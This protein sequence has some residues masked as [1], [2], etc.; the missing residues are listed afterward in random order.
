MGGIALKSSF[1]TL[2]KVVIQPKPPALLTIKPLGKVNVPIASTFTAVAASV[3]TKFLFAKFD[4]RLIK[5]AIFT[6]TDNRYTDELPRSTSKFTAFE[7]ISGIS[8]TRPE[9]LSV[10][11]F[12]PI[13][14]NNGMG[15]TAA[16][17][18]LDAQVKLMN[19]R[20]EAMA[21]LIKDLKTDPILAEQLDQI[22][23]DFLVHVK[24]LKDRVEFLATLQKYTENISKM[25]DLRDAQSTV[26]AASVLAY[27]YNALFTNITS[28]QSTL[29]AYTYA[30][31]LS[32]HGFNKQSVSEFSSTK[33]F[34]QTLYEA[35]KILR[36]GSDELVG[37]DASL[38]S[39]DTDPVTINRRVYRDPH[40]ALERVRM[41][42]LEDLRTRR[43]HESDTRLNST[44][45]ELETDFRNLDNV[46]TGATSEEVSY[47]LKI[48]TL[49]REAAYSHALS[50]TVTAGLL[51]DYGYPLR[52][53]IGNQ[54]LFDAVFGQLGSRITDNRTGTNSN[55][56]SSIVSKVDGDKAVL[57]YEVD[58]LEDEQ[59]SVFTPGASYY[60]T[61]AVRPGIS[62]AFSHEHAAELVTRMKSVVDHYANFINCFNLLPRVGNVKL[63]QLAN[64]VFVLE[65]TAMTNAL[66]G[67]L[68]ENSNGQLKS[69]VIG[70]PIID[71]LGE[72]AT[73]IG[74]RANLLLYIACVTNISDDGLVAVETRGVDLRPEAYKRIADQEY[75]NALVG[76]TI[77]KLVKN[78]VSYY[79][80]ITGDTSG[81][82]KVDH[83]LRNYN[84]QGPLARSIAF[85]KTSY[86]VY[87]TIVNAGYT[88]Y[89]HLSNLQMVA[90]S[91]QT[92]LDTVRRY[93]YNRT[94]VNLATHVNLN[95]K[96]SAIASL[97]S[98]S[99]VQTAPTLAVKSA[100]LLA[101]LPGKTLGKAKGAAV[102]VAPL[103]PKPSAYLTISHFVSKLSL[104]QAII[105][106]LEREELLMIRTALAPLHAMRLVKDNLHEFVL[107]LQKEENTK[108]IN[109]IL[110]IVGDRKLVELLADKGQVRILYDTVSTV[111]QKISLSADNKANT[112][113]ADIVSLTR[114]G[115]PD[116]DLKVFDDSFITSK[117]S[118]I[119]KAAL[120]TAKFSP[121]RG[122]NIRVIA[123]GLP[124]GFSTHLNNKFKITTFAEQTR[125]KRKQ[126]DVIVADV[127]KIDVRYP[128]LIF[129]PI[130]KVLEMSRFV[131]RNENVFD[132][133]QVGASL[134]TALNAIPTNDY[135][136]FS[137]V[138]QAKGGITLKGD[139]SF[140]TQ[141]DADAL[142]RNTVM[143][144]LLEIYY[145]L[146]TGIP[147][148]ERELY[149]VDPDEKD[150]P[151]EFIT[152]SILG[153]ATATILKEP[154]KDNF[155]LDFSKISAPKLI[156]YISATQAS[157]SISTAKALVNLK[158]KSDILL[159]AQEFV[160]KAQ[161]KT[162]AI[163]P[164]AAQA[165][166]KKTVYT[167][168]ARAGKYMMSPKLFERVFFVDV[169]P[170]DFEIDR[171]ETFRNDVGRSTF[172]QLQQAGEVV[173]YTETLGNMTR[174]SYYLKD[175]RAE[176]QMTFEK[177][178]IVVRAYTPLATRTR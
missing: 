117:T 105:A 163:A 82:S 92:V 167:D 31:L 97:A 148:S 164:V 133:V 71:L 94:R 90:L 74:L 24:N 161:H 34:L 111:L 99:T 65:P 40:I 85:I 21:V 178:F 88:R 131:V 49:S 160:G 23:G 91:L 51:N 124:H 174:D 7:E 106:R 59:G 79:K 142:G 171:E 121:D 110:S 149:V 56:V 58:Y 68:V 154:P 44:I 76:P 22:E 42:T 87:R 17:E 11:E 143:S 61:S 168:R 177:Y 120:A 48:K 67:L 169:D 27:Y 114:S 19:L 25:L 80:S 12:K 3:Q 13:F 146:L 141:A 157:K 159:T 5:D 54:Q 89:S 136:D 78:C 86:D 36:A 135:S 107:Y 69:D 57:T 119:L 138:T 39:R 172:T 2:A 73:H 84:E 66:Y 122:S 165:S 103:I 170:D 4:F 26:D 18:F 10:S 52:T 47:T 104:K 75:R 96:V 109:D 123:F 115:G 16:G 102:T 60:V 108:V 63:N 20:H 126:N 125:S 62:S 118:N 28:A 101:K 9:I 50:N 100:A 128:D 162:Q 77:D 173:T 116:D 83:A 166:T 53:D 150:R 15:F 55:S 176:K 175:H 1:A 127:Y 8:S 112:D 41:S 153:K 134:N 129:K 33:V 151:A 144:Y 30:D 35:R 43:I 137:N 145:R 46:F 93:S 45:Q 32:Q 156:S 95:F 113:L 140:M 152:R 132:S 72:A 147:L 64:S 155:K 29:S 130:P 37:T 70:S 98:I 14:S 6:P 139:Y 81:A 38:A 158:I